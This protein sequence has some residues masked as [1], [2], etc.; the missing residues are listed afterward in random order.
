MV[1]LLV[2]IAIIV[3]LAG[4]VIGIGGWSIEQGRKRDTAGLFKHLDDAIEQFRL[5]APLTR[6][7]GMARYGGY[8]PDE[9]EAFVSGGTDAG[10]PGSG[11]IIRPNDTADL[12]FELSDF[13]NVGSRDVKAMV[14]AIRLFGGEEAQQILERIDAR[15]RAGAPADEYWDRNGNDSFDPEDEPLAFYVDSWGVPIEYFALCPPGPPLNVPAPSDSGGNRY[16]ACTWLVGRNKQRP[17]F[18]SYGPDGP[19]QFSGDFGETDLLS[20]FAGTTPDGDTP[21]IIDNRFNTDNV[22][23]TEGLAEKL[24]T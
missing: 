10:I 19:D 24:R 12:S 9:L 23:S 11:E 1:E 3:L 4:L 5:D 13:E 16:A 20:D 8:P 22:Y 15:F 17:L 2:V 21:G 18:A 14:L 7:Q 6:V